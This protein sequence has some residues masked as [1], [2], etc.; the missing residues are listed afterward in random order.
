MIMIKQNERTYEFTDEDINRIEAKAMMINME[1]E[2]LLDIIRG[3]KIKKIK[4]EQAKK[5]NKPLKDL[6][7]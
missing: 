3:K 2:A 4:T 7:K 1:S 6:W 5:Y